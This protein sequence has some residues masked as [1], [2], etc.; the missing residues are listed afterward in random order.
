[1]NDFKDLGIKP[2]EN[3][4]RGEKI[5]IDSILNVDIIVEKFA[6]EDS[7]FKV[8][9]KRVCYQLIVDNRERICFCGSKS[10]HDMILRV[11]KDKF[12]I[13]TKIVKAD[14]RLVFT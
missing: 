12:P 8:G 7:K 13:K 10:L 14:K 4:Y 5:H 9:E 3:K 1:M 6:V 11:P 2:P